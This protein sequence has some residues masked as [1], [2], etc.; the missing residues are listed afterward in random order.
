MKKIILLIAIIFSQISHAQCWTNLAG[1]G[2]HTLSIREDGTLWA[3]GFNAYGQLGNGN[4]VNSLSPV[5]IGTARNWKMVSA[6][7]YFSMGI[8]TDGTLWAWGDN[9]SGQLGDGTLTGKTVP[10][11]IGTDTDWSFGNLG[12]YHTIAVKTNGTLWAWGENGY[13]QLGNGNTVDQLS[14][15]QIGSATN[16][17]TAS[18]GDDFTMAIQSNGTLWGFGR[19]NFGELGDGTTTQRI[20]PTLIGGAT[21]WMNVECAQAHS[22]ALKTDGTLWSWGYNTEGALGLGSITNTLVPSQVGFANNWNSINAHYRQSIATKT[23]GSF[24]SFGYNAL[25]QLGD[26]TTVNRNLPV[27]IASSNCIS[28]SAGSNHTLIL[29]GNGTIFGTGTNSAGQL[30]DG[31]TTG[32]T[33]PGIILSPDGIANAFAGFSLLCPGDTTE[34]IAI[35]T[36]KSD[37]GSLNGNSSGFFMSLSGQQT[38]VPSLAGMLR[39]I[40]VHTVT[41]GNSTNVNVKLY[42]GSPGSGTQL[43]HVTY[44]KPSGTNSWDDVVLPAGITV[45]AGL[46]YYI[47]IAG[48]SQVDWIYNNTNVY[49]SGNAWKGGTSYS[50]FDYNFETF[51][52]FNSYQWNPGPTGLAQFTV[53]PGSSMNYSVTVSSVTGCINKK[54]VFLYVNPLLNSGIS[55]TNVSCNAGNDGVIDL[56]VTG[57][58]APYVFAW[59]NGSISEDLTGLFPGNY[60]VTVTDNLGCSV[61]ASTTISQPPV[62]VSSATLINTITCYGGTGLVNVSAN[63]GVPPYSG[64]GSFTVTA[65]TFS[66]TVIDAAGCSTTTTLNVT[67]PSPIALTLNSPS[68][69]CSG[70]TVTLT[71]LGATSYTW[72]P[73]GIAGSS[74]V[75]SP[76]SSII[77]TVTGVNSNGCTGSNTISVNVIPKPIVSASSPSPTI[78]SGSSAQL[79]A[80]G[81][82]SYT[83]N[84][85]T[86]LSHS[87]SV[88]PLSSTVY[89]LSGEDI[90]GCVNSTT[91]GVT[92]YALPVLTASGSSSVI[93]AGSTATLVASGASSYTWNPGGAIGASVGVSASINTIYTVTGTSSNGCDNFAT[94]SLT[95]N[96][97]PVIS[98]LPPNPIVCSG[99][100]LALFASGAN[101]YTWS[102]GPVLNT[103]TV[104]PSSP[105]SYSLTGTDMNGCE[106]TTSTLV[107]VINTPVVSINSPSTNVCFGYTMSVV[108]SGA[109]NYL[110]SNG[111]TTNSTVIQPFTNSTF[112]VVGNNGGTCSDTAYL[113]INVLPLPTVNANSSTSLAC[114]GQTITLNASGT[115]VNYLWKPGNL[116]GATQN[117][118]ISVPTTFTVY[119]QGAN[120]CVYFSTVD[121]NVQNSNGSLHPLVSPEI[122]C[123]GDSVRLSV[124]GGSVPSWSL[125]P[126]PGS[127][128]VTPVVST[129]YSFV[130]LDVMGCTSVVSF[131]VNIHTDCDVI[132]YNGLSPNGDGINDTWVIDHIERYA[133]NRVIVYSRWGLKMF[134]TRNY[135]NLNNNWDGKF[136]G[137]PV[138]TGTYFFIILTDSDKLLKKGWIEVT[139]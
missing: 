78:C 132:S 104:S 18:G 108:A 101:T 7:I 20:V 34:L 133:G 46:P 73:G 124:I 105:T 139:H 102:G 23:D 28:G 29:K 44:F 36:L 83:W 67:E 129:T 52:D 90:T 135:D 37:Q 13:G 39:K 66:F 119:G 63:G 31:T 115:A 70:D 22:I 130:A 45:S 17:Q 138:E 91:I 109:G 92:V 94:Y 137:S 100:T 99:N 9:A 68:T 113:S 111:A 80:S 4:T 114:T 21:T 103:Y 116:V 82:N 48:G 117:V 11:Q 120:G 2:N 88:S 6:G 16:W 38:F 76:S 95:V 14:P 15:V 35:G 65:G 49:S 64:T 136:K 30:G 86:I 121:V 118:Q 131:P 96:P 106:G 60:S 10:T 25:G 85:G 75:V 98:I 32:R 125:N 110:W 42:S 58:T 41:Y 1:G 43:A 55:V 40:R 51:M 8:K 81:A 134:Q 62:L 5:Q 24:W 97:L 79:I 57:G 19:N 47:E 33:T 127:L 3:W 59:S 84:P 87:V 122:I 53:A 89:T 50:G 71:A 56:N 61:T 27:Q 93:C 77:Y 74:A 126:Y 107:N 26:G 128:I 72:Q 54:S 12:G 112:S 69:V 123:I